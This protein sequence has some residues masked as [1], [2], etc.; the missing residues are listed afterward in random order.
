MQKD[1]DNCPVCEHTM[2]I[3][4]LSCEHCGARISGRLGVPNY[5]LSKLNQDQFEFLI[6]F[7]RCEGKYNRMEEE[8]KVSYPTLKN[9]FN[10][11][12]SVV[13][14]STMKNNRLKKLAREER[15]D[16]L[17][18]LDEGKISTEEAEMLLRGQDDPKQSQRGSDE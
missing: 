7:I 8:L 13:D 16:I 11:L 14:F 15:I 1:I 12:L 18:K 2:T 17:K 5:P 10:D 3:T 9:R 6:T 4:E